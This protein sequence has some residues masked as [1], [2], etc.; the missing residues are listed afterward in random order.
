MPAN[1]RAWLV[2]TGRFKAI[3]ALRRR[4]RFDA[5]LGELAER[6]EAESADADPADDEALEDDRL[7]LDLHLLPSRAAA[8]RADRAHAARGLRPHHRGDR[9][10][11]PDA[12]RRRWRSGSSAPRPRS[13]TRA[14]PIRCPPRADLPERL[15]SVLHVIYLV[16][17]EGYSA[18]SGASLTRHDLSAEAIRLGRLLVELLPASRR[19]SGCSR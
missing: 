5:S 3:D 15:D 12:A 16:F 14:F 11:V 18:S 17:N 6:L 13:A 10:R 1:P 7:R 8:R 9:P 4:A 2:S 19:R